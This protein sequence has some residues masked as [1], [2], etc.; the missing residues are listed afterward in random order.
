MYAIRD[1]GGKYV[2]REVNNTYRAGK[3]LLVSPRAFCLSP[4]G[5]DHI[6]IGGHD[7]SNR[8]SD[9]MA[10]VFDA[11]REVVLGDREGSD[12]E[13]GDHRSPRMPRVDDGPI[14]ELRVYIAN[15]GRFQHMVKRFREHTDRIFKKNG[16]EPVGY[17]VRPDGNDRQ[18]RTFYYILKHPSRYA[19]FRNWNNFTNDREWQSV[20]EKPEF[21]RLLIQKP[22]S[23][24]MTANG[25]AEIVGVADREGG[26][27]EL[28]TYTA[29][30]GK[31]AEFN[32]RFGDG[33]A[34]IVERYEM[35]V[36]AYWTPFDK[37]DLESKLICLVHH[38]DRK[39]ADASWAELRKDPDWNRIE[40]SRLLISEP[41]G[42][43][44]KATE[45]SPLR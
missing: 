28:R 4:F 40:D 29:K 23:V 44:L 18:R 37:P 11:P 16:M 1:S 41:G 17:W 34:E 8:V 12:A 9:D 32:A 6:Y 31:L 20:L 13:S 10:W 43:F 30:P 33:A 42:I 5:D 26:L 19:A 36:L 27:F 7:S 45:F 15:D 35:K 3:P 14:Y 2:V 24:F 39:T 22:E 38:R 25:N 21:Q